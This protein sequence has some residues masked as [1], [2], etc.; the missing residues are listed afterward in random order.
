M[1]ALWM[2]GRTMAGRM[3][4]T[5]GGVP[6]RAAPLKDPKVLSGLTIPRGMGRLRGWLRADLD[7]RPAR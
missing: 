2:T 3:L 4:Q 5:G 7:A 1:A 6:F